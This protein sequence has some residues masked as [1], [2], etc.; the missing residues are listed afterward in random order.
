LRV[1]KRGREKAKGG[2]NLV[3]GRQ[4]ETMGKVQI[5]WLGRGKQIGGTE[6]HMKRK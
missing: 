6:K 1:E 3:A 4:E 2:T 5:E